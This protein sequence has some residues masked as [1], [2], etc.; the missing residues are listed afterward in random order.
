LRVPSPPPG[1]GV[2]SIFFEIIVG[3]IQVQG[4]EL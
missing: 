2:I 4:A 1:S 3:V